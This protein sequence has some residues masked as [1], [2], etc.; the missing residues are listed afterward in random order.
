MRKDQEVEE[1]A[2]EAVEVEEVAVEAGIREIILCKSIDSEEEVTEMEEEEKKANNHKM[3]V[4]QSN[5]DKNKYEEL[6]FLRLSALM[7]ELIL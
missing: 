6:S 3:E 2:E 4:N 5:K 7:A 1:V